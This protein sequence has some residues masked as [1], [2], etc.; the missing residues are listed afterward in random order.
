MIT[1]V[2]AMNSTLAA[3]LAE[4]ANHQPAP[5]PPSGIPQDTVTLSPE[6]K[7][8]SAHAA[9]IDHDGDSH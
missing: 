2:S 6:A 5:A 3:Q 1:G 9:D 4:Q 7:Q 8:A